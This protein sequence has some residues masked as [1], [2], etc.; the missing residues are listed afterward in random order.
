MT[1][2]AIRILDAHSGHRVSDVFEGHTSGVSSMA[3]SPNGKHLA[4]GSYDQ[5]VRVWEVESNTNSFIHAEHPFNSVAFSPTGRQVVSSSCDHKVVT[6]E[7][8]T[9]AVVSKFEGHTKNIT[10][11]AFSPDGKSVVSGSVDA[12]VRVWDTQSGQTVSIA[13]GHNSP[14]TCVAFFPDGERFV[15]GFA[16]S[17]IWVWCAETGEPV[18]GPFDDVIKNRI[19][20]SKVTS[21][22]LSPDGTL[23]VSGYWDSRITVWFA[24]TGTVF[25]GPI[26]EFDTVRSVA[27]SPDGK[28]IVSD[29]DGG[30]FRIRDTTT[31]ETVATFEG[32]EWYRH[33]TCAVFSP[34]GKRIVSCSEGNTIRVWDVSTGTMIVGPLEG[35]GRI[36]NC[37]A[38]SPDGTHVVSSSWDQTIR[39]W[40]VRPGEMSSNKML[41]H[42]GECEWPDDTDTSQNG[43][44][45]KSR[46]E[47]GWILNSHSELLFWVPPRYR[48]TLW[49]PRNTVVI[50]QQYTKLDLSLFVHGTNWQQCKRAT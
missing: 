48:A 24:D 1:D 8:D 50:G 25:A 23:I 30:S 21:V 43:F 40:D 28:S 4:S 41:T 49:W 9:G 22:A 6:W 33:V 3:F 20:G 12:T 17:E 47:D 5:T 34:D 37:V 35:H 36:V 19:G 14:V 31:L 11:V 15:S 38:F 7:V 32:H 2:F 27:F 26:E 10:S 46:W 42:T 13:N 44:T 18:L 29:S 39:I 16:D 45:D